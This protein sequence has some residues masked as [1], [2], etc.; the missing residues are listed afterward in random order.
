MP[1]SAATHPN[2][3]SSQPPTDDLAVPPDL[4]VPPDLAPLPGP[5]ITAI[6][7]GLGPNTGNT[8]ITITGTN[9][10][11][12]ATVTVAGVACAN[13]TVVSAT[14][15]TC[16]TAAKAAT[17]GP[18]AVVVT[19]P[20]TQIATDSTKFS[21]SS[22]AI[23]FGNTANFASAATATRPDPIIVADLNGDARPDVVTNSIG[24][25]NITVRLSTC[26]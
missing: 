7:P 4:T 1:Q 22:A 12:G 18:V 26:Q 9:F 8:L 3:Y 11:T 10:Q 17:C 2:A 5:T 23:A 13:P 16:T 21:F 15:I 24:T 20:D 19:N 25:N 14:S 6:A